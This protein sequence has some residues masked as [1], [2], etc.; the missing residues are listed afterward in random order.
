MGFS[1][2]EGRRFV[3]ESIAGTKVVSDRDVNDRHLKD[4]SE[5]IGLVVEYLCGSDRGRSGDSGLIPK[6]WARNG[7]WTLCKRMKRTSDINL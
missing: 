4:I 7:S 1:G 3:V 6:S 2:C 5:Y